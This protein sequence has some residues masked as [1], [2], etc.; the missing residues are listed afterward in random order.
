MSRV[1]ERRAQGIL[2]KKTCLPAG[3]EELSCLYVLFSVLHVC[4]YCLV[5]GNSSNH[6]VNRCDLRVIVCF[7]Q[8]VLLICFVYYRLL[9]LFPRGV[10]GVGQHGLAADGA[11]GEGAHPVD[12]VPHPGIKNN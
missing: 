6:I 1:S 8:F 5:W 9:M 7:Y 2:M 11:Q 3:S 4:C 10:R 12:G